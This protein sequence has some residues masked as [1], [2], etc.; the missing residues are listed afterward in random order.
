MIHATAIKYR[1]IGLL[2][3]GMSG[4]GKSELALRLIKHGGILIAD[5]QVRLENQNNELIASAPDTL[6]GLIEVYGIGIV[7]QDYVEQAPIHAVLELTHRDYIERLPEP[8]Y[9]MLEGIKLPRIAFDP[10]GNA[11]IEKLDVIVDCIAGAMMV[12]GCLENGQAVHAV[13]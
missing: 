9:D 3:T 5:D 11:A 8:A 13:S 10:F 1:K 2:I 12:D 7:K 6:R 4:A